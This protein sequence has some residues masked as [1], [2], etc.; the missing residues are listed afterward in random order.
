MFSISMVA[1]TSSPLLLDSF[2]TFDWYEF[3]F[4]IFLFCS[5]EHFTWTKLSNHGYRIQWLDFTNLEPW[6]YVFFFG[7]LQGL[8]HPFANVI[9]SSSR[10]LSFAI[11]QFL[12]ILNAFLNGLKQA[13]SNGW[14]T[15][16]VCASK[17]TMSKLSFIVP[18]RASIVTCDP[19]PLGIKKCRF[20]WKTP[21]K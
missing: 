3:I 2:V 17:V 14:S 12:S 1:L 15:C 4:M 9:L 11:S 20:F 13:M 5:N 6:F 21:L 8:V 18:S 19:C 10:Y 16:E 7:L